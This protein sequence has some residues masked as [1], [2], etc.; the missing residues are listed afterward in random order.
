MQER[1][2]A[3]EEWKMHLGKKK[4]EAWLKQDLGTSASTYLGN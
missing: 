4:N 3:E 2:G 1:E